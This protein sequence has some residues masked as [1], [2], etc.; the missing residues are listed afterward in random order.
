MATIEF[1]NKYLNLIDNKVNFIDDKLNFVLALMNVESKSK[2][3][4][5]YE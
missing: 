1:H 2:L 3:K 5:K 4:K